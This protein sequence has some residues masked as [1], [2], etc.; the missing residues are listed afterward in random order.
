M[1]VLSRHK[2]Q[3]ISLADGLVDVTVVE[4][5]PETVRLGITAPRSVPIVR[6]ELAARQHTAGDPG[7]FVS[8]A[9]WQILQQL[10]ATAI[11]VQP[12]NDP[13]FMSEFQFSLAD[14]CRVMDAH[15]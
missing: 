6:T 9:E 15:R 7:R 14:A 13:T 8:A 11:N 1:L 4:T 2:S 3:S 10:V 5:R 12:R